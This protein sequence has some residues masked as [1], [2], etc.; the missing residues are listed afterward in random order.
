MNVKPSLVCIFEQS[1]DD[2]TYRLGTRRID[3]MTGILHSQASAATLRE[4]AKTRLVK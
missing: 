4:A 2:S 1:I 3:P